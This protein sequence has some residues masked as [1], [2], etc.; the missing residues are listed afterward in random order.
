VTVDVRRIYPDYLRVWLDPANPVTSDPVEIA[1]ILEALGVCPDGFERV[2]KLVGEATQLLLPAALSDVS[3]LYRIG[4]SPEREA[5]R[6]SGDPIG[7]YG[8][9]LVLVWRKTESDF[10]PRRG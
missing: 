5:S 3:R 4:V 6:F 1:Y 9:C 2:L 7:R 10:R 8:G